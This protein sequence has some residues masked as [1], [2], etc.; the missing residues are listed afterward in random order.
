MGIVPVRFK[1]SALGPEVPAPGGPRAGASD[2]RKHCSEGDRPLLADRPTTAVA[3]LRRLRALWPAGLG[4]A[5]AA[6]LKLLIAA[7]LVAALFKY[8]AISLGDLAVI[9]GE[10]LAALAATLLLLG[11]SLV[12]VLRWLVLLRALGIALPFATAFQIYYIGAF[13][14]TFLPG[15][16]GGDA[17]RAFYILRRSPDRPAASLLSVLADRLFGL[18]GLLAVAAALIV[19]NHEAVFTNPA[20]AMFA[21]AILGLFLGMVVLGGLA[22]LFSERLHLFGLVRS[23]HTRHRLAA[24][25]LAVIEVIVS[26][27]RNLSALLAAAGLSMILTLLLIAALLVVASAFDYRGPGLPGYAIA[28]VFSLLANAVPLSP[29]GIGI[30]EAAFDQVCRLLE[31]APSAAPYGTIFFA[32]RIVLT[33]VNLYGVVPFILYRHRQAVAAP[34]TD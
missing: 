5:R 6:L 13:A 22:T 15:T 19:G 1:N 21:T 2:G 3:W 4:K 33:L 17:L 12:G 29:G 34:R 23:W 31:A 10:P 20:T 26:Y 7:L 30:G 32:F 11:A 14:S 27:R 16:V 18:L 25:L 9:A 28:A 24:G 8:G